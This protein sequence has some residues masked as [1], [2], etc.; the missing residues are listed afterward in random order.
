MIRRVLCR[1][2]GLMAKKLAKINQVDQVKGQ[3]KMMDLTVGKYDLVVTQGASYATKRIEALNMLMELMRVNPA[4]LNIGGD[5]MMKAMDWDGS[6]EM[7]ERLK[8]CYR[9]NCRKTTVNRNCRPA[10]RE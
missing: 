9:R 8:K 7:A 2:W 4:M 3:P 5:L 10:C 1:S 6:D